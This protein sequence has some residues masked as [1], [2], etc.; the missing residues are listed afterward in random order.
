MK[1]SVHDGDVYTVVRDVVAASG[2]SIRR[3]DGTGGSLEDLFFQHGQD[4]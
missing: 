4:Q 1:V 2:A 3:L